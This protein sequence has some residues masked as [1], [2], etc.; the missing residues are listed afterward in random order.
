MGCLTAFATG[1]VLTATA[2]ALPVVVTGRAIQGLGGGGLVPVTL[3]MVASR[4]PP[5]SRGL[6]LGIVGAV[7]ELGSVVGPLYGAAVVAVASWRAIFWIN[8]PVTAV[9]A[10]GLWWTRDRQRPP[11][12]RGSAAAGRM[13]LVGT[14]LAVVG[15]AAVLVGLDAPNRLATSTSVGQYWS[16]AASGPWASLTTPVVLFGA[17]LLVVFVAWEVAAPS[18]PALSSP[19]VAPRLSSPKPT[20]RARCCRPGCSAASWCCSRRPIRAGRCSHP[21]HR[22]SGR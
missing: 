18:A 3:A 5:D 7:Q 11:P 13:D 4:W 10:V 2:H 14:V 6:P 20:C 1:S 15:T 12:S 19:S 16:P 8:V 17:G 21:A 9:L 22:C